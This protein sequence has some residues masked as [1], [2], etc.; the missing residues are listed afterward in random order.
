MGEITPAD[1][2]RWRGGDWRGFVRTCCILRRPDGT[3]GPL[4]VSDRQ[5]AWLDAIAARR[6]DGAP[7][8]TTIGIVSPKR[9]GKTTIAAAAALYRT[10]LDE[11]RLTIFLGNSRESAESLSFEC[12]KEFLR[13]GPLGVFAEVRRSRISLPALNS[14]MRAVPCSAKTVAGITVTGALVSDELWQA[15]DE[16]PWQL[17]SS[18]KSGNA[19]AIMVSQASGLHSAVHRL[20][21]TAQ[22]QEPDHLWFDYV[23]PEWIDAH[24]SPNPYLDAAYI[25]ERR[26]ELGIEAVFDHYF[27][28]I[29]GGGGG[30][31]VTPA[32]LDAC[33]LDAELPRNVHEVRALLADLGADLGDCAFASAL[34]RAMPGNATGDDSVWVTT[35]TLPADEA[36]LRRVLVVECNVLPTGSE[37]EV[38]AARAA[39]ERLVGQPPAVA[40][41]VYQAA[42]LAR[43]LGAQVISPSPPRQAE[44]FT[45]LGR[46]LSE[47]LL[48]IPAD[49]ELLL[50]QLAGFGVDTST[51]PPRFG[52]KVNGNGDDAVYA[53]AMA[54]ERGRRAPSGRARASVIVAVPAAAMRRASSLTRDPAVRSTHEQRAKLK[55]AARRRR[56]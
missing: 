14:E 11:D 48:V 5:A 44:Q 51:Q 7:C 35:A 33:T 8:Y 29:W 19:Q 1:L 43:R 13:R 4:E 12:A 26:V 20:F 39:T 53:L 55:A 21:V 36:G 27:R 9:S 22:D 45:R 52:K 16:E 54:C 38:M 42:D 46:L 41:E 2:A 6:P 31:F 50:R 34:D 17:L 28:N 18:Q 10:A 24:L 25:G 3:V 47:H 32:D 15:D 49:A 30:R 40:V 56:G 23:P 37:A